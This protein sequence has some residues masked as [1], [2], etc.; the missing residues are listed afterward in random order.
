MNFNGVCS[1][2][3]D[4]IESGKGILCAPTDGGTKQFKAFIIVFED[5]D[6][7]NITITDR[8]IARKTFARFELMGWNCHLFEHMKRDLNTPTKD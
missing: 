4:P 7:S 8:A 1:L 5:Q 2:D 3:P 6:R